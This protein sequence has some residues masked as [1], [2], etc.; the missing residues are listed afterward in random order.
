MVLE[1]TKENFDNV[2]SDSE[3]TVVQFS[4]P[5]C[6][7]CRMLAPIISE[8]A[9]EHS[10]SETLKIGK[11]NVDENTDLAMKYGIRGIPSILF[12]KEGEVIDRIVGMKAKHEIQEKINSLIN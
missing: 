3:L 11:V 1:L 6:G 4:A 9:E 7:P 10:E 8:I 2:L 12:I 5:W